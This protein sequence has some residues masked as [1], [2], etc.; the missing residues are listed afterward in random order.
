MNPIPR[1]YRRASST[2]IDASLKPVIGPYLRELD[3]RLRHAGFPGCI[4]GVAS[5]GGVVETETLAAA[6]IHARN[7]GPSLAP[8]AGRRYAEVEIGW[9]AF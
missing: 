1:E 8:L 2:C 6:P 5:Q 4:L 7:S 3:A 9:D